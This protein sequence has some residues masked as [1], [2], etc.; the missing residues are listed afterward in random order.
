MVLAVVY[1]NGTEDT[2]SVITGPGGSSLRRKIMQIAT[3]RTQ[4]DIVTISSAILIFL[5]RRSLLP[6]QRLA[7]YHTSGY[8]HKSLRPEALGD[9]LFIRE[10]AHDRLALGLDVGEEGHLHAAEG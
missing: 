8:M 2:F 7:F 3:T 1:D 9:D 10:E 5:Y 6:I 4:I